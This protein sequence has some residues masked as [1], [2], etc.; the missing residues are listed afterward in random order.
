MDTPPSRPGRASGSRQASRA[1]QGAGAIK[2]V[3][4]DKDGTLI[5]FDSTWRGAFFEVALELTRQDP[6]LTRELM[7][8]GGWDEESQSFRAGSLCAAGTSLE[9]AEHW[10]GLLP[11]GPDPVRMAEWMDRQFALAGS[12]GVKAVTPLPA[13]FD[14]L[15]SRGLLLGVATSD[16][17]AGATAC[18]KSLGAL[19][20]LSFIAGYDSGHGVKPSAGMALAFCRHLGIRPSQIAVVG[21]NLHD[22]EMGRAAGAGLL[23]GVLSG[24]SLASDLEAMADC[25][26]LDISHLPNALEG[27]DSGRDEEAAPETA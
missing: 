19:D 6:V 18:L 1:R 21:D 5:D 3:L 2:A 17:E 13:L 4:F 11:E 22:M 9:L 24:T 15:A 10:S 20:R 8:A 25:I 12:T 27:R 14:E 7:E 16:S 26:L 23:V